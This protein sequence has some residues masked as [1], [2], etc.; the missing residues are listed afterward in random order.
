MTKRQMMTVQGLNLLH[1]KF[2]LFSKLAHSSSLMPKWCIIGQ[3]RKNRQTQMTSAITKPLQTNPLTSNGMQ[4]LLN[5]SLQELSWIIW[6]RSLSSQ[7]RIRIEANVLACLAILKI[8]CKTRSKKWCSLK[9]THRC[10][11][12]STCIILAQSEKV[13]LPTQLRTLG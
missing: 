11:Q 3:I 12:K 5:W 7:R 6:S 1:L 13:K 8:W 4:Q 10:K 2:W 9:Q